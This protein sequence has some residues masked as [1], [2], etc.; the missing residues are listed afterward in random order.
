MATADSRVG[1]IEPGASVHGSDGGKL[2]AVTEVGADYIVVERG[3]LQP[4]SYVVPADAVA[5]AA[6]GD[7]TLTMSR[8]E[9]LAQGWDGRPASG[10]ASHRGGPTAPNDVDG[11][12]LPEADLSTPG[13]ASMLGTTMPAADFA[14]LGVAPAD[15]NTAYT[16]DDDPAVTAVRESDDLPVD[17]FPAEIHS[18]DGR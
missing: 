16:G 15:R 8:D 7:V 13:M 10:E 12:G 1:E 4:T 18:R 11:D 14:T 6:G 3:L 17:G 9:A 2:G 5:D